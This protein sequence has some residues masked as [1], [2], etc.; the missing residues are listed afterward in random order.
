M[1]HLEP[2]TGDEAMT[3]VRFADQ[4]DKL[5]ADVAAHKLAISDNEARLDRVAQLL[6][7]AR[8]Q[9]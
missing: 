8:E 3:A 5:I 9:A 4:V 1:H 6:G 2:L 7:V